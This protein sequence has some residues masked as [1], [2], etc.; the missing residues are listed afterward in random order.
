[1]ASCVI[2]HGG[3]SN[4]ELLDAFQ[5]MVNRFQDTTW[6]TKELK[7]S[8]E[9]WIAAS[10]KEN[11][12]LHCQLGKNFNVGWHQINQQIKSAV[13]QGTRLIQYQG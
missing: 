13:V 11:E 6:V 9:E 7:K 12:H 8:L 10:K 3:M 4:I 1:M 2:A 5:K